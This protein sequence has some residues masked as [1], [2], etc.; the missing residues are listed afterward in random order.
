MRT[1]VGGS[2][3]VWRKPTSAPLSAATASDEKDS[4]PVITRGFPSR[5]NS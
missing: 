5:G 1:S 3:N 4:S 2:M